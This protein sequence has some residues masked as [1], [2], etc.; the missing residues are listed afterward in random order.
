MTRSGAGGSYSIS[1]C[2]SNFLRKVLRFRPSHSRCTR[3]VL[4]SVC[5]H[6]DFEQSGFSITPSPSCRTGP[7]GSVPCRSLKVRL[8]GWRARI[9]SGDLFFAHSSDS[10][11]VSCVYRGLARRGQRGSSPCAP[12]SV[13]Q[14]IE[15]MGYGCQLRFAACQGQ[16]HVPPES[17]PLRHR[18]GQALCAYQ[19]YVFAGRCARR[20]IHHTSC[21]DPCRCSNKQ[22]LAP[23][24]GQRR[25]Q[26]AVPVSRE[27]DAISRNIQGRPCA[28]RPTITAS[29]PV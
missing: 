22:A 11:S 3:L 15:K 26:R 29:A 25:R 9:R 8:P 5:C 27:S 6:H 19:A 14:P 24:A 28:A 18:H 12:C 21:N 17:C 2:A 10:L 16:I 23:P 1:L 13:F 4:I 7:A 20:R